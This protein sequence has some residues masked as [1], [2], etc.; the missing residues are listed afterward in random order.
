MAYETNLLIGCVFSLFVFGTVH[1]TSQSTDYEL[2]ATCY[3]RSVFTNIY[4]NL[5]DSIRTH[6]IGCDSGE[7]H[8]ELLSLGKPLKYDS[9]NPGRRKQ[10][11]SLSK[12]NSL[13]I[14]VVENALPFVD[15]IFPTKTAFNTVATKSQSDYNYESLSSTFSYI[16]RHMMVNPKNFSS[17]EVLKAKYY[18]QEL[19]PNSEKVLI[20]DAHSLPRLI[21]YDYYRARYLEESSKRDSQ[22][23]KNRL[24][25]TQSMFEE[26]GKK[27]L[28][29]LTSDV[30]AAYTKW[31]ILGYK[32]EVENQLQ[33]FDIDRQED[34]LMSTRALF[35]A[36]ARSS[37][38]DPHIRVYPFTFIPDDWYKILKN[39]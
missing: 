20:E 26:W 2:T 19:V 5:H 12:F 8:V 29:P 39:P 17:D 22:V 35:R 33:Y 13:P 7:R 31:Q 4:R 3:S 10:P 27:Q 24:R 25:L 11:Q 1:S 38:R 15:K 30:D 16:L 6:V 18:L 34:K 9:F 23:N 14:S 37:E 28:P 21:L 32:T 36:A